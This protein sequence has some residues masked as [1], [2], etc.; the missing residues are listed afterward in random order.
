V[1]DTDQG[2]QAT[3]RPRGVG[4]AMTELAAIAG[5]LQADPD[6]AYTTWMG[7]AQRMAQLVTD[8]MA[9]GVL[10]AAREG[11]TLSRAQARLVGRWVQLMEHVASLGTDRREGRLTPAQYNDADE[12]AVRAAMLLRAELERAGVRIAMSERIGGSHG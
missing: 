4:Q 12:A 7:D 10:P 2:G 5:A 6:R 1:T 11:V 8:I 9:Q 3:G